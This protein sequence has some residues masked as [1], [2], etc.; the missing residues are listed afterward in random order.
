MKTLESLNLSRSRGETGRGK[1]PCG[2]EHTD[3]RKEGH[4]GQA[5]A[6]LRERG[7]MLRTTSSEHGAG[8]LFLL[9]VSLPP[10]H[11]TPAL[12]HATSVSP[13]ATLPYL[14]VSLFMEP[15]AT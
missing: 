1:D 12:P 2:K 15:S 9:L 5:L 6:F 3:S 7:D 11:P 14:S 10:P 4:Y 8:D 13:L